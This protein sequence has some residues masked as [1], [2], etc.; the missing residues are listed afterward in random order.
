MALRRVSV[1]ITLAWLVAVGLPALAATP[2]WLTQLEHA[3]HDDPGEVLKS[4]KA[5]RAQ[6][7]GE[8][9]K[10]RAE[11]R[12]LIAALELEEHDLAE[13]ALPLARAHQQA[14]GP[15]EAWCVAAMAEPVM[16]WRKGE[17][18]AARS[19]MD[20]AVASARASQEDWCI[21]RM[22]LTQGRQFL[23]DGRHG[24][25]AAP[26]HE[27]L[28][29]FE[30]HGEKEMTAIV[31][32]HLAW[33]AAR[34][35]PKASLDDAIGKSRAALA[36]LP[37][38]MPRLLVGSIHHDLGSMLMDAG[39]FNDARLHLETSLKLAQEVKHD[40]AEGYIERL[41]ARLYLKEKQPA[42]ALRHALQ[43][44][45]IFERKGV[46]DMTAYAA[47]IVADAQ[48]QLNRPADALKTLQDADALRRKA[49]FPETDVAHWRLSLAAHTRL[50]HLK[51]AQE[52]ADAFV[53][54]VEHQEELVRQKAVAEANAQFDVERREAEN[55]RLREQQAANAS[56]Q[57]WLGLSLLL[58]CLLLALLAWHA[59]RQRRERLRLRML[60]EV[61]ELTGLPNRRA[62]QESLRQ[63]VLRAKVRGEPFCLAICDIDHFKRVNDR[64]GHDVGDEALRCFAQAGR[65]ALRSGDTFGRY[66]GEEFLILMRGSTAAAAPAFERLASLLR[67]TP[68]PG[69]PED[70]R[71]SFSMGVASWQPET[72]EA[73]LIQAADQALYRAKAA[74]RAR[75]EIAP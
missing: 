27:A 10:A 33:M 26:L 34:A 58:A 67:Q 74:G 68:V 63:D 75:F 37:Q 2:S 14:G 13:F 71:L 59:L 50:G 49:S 64:F 17:M 24:D 43:A 6:A 41:L 35:G 70:E 42:D 54:A 29:Y 40:V 51:A 11:T 55:L 4:A 60:A 52:A 73:A 7:T 15:A 69:M 72:S 44:Y 22:L 47:T 8:A 38:P 53:A 5:E 45:Q 12:L 28:A 9:A 36:L 19:T 61:D 21:A 57:F 3:V 30:R 1:H 66:G 18:A 23:D 39:K 56:R 16:L 62:L 25:A 32:S 31:M 20:K 46:D 65:T 48:L